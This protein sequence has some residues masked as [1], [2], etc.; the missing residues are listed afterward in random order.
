MSDAEAPTPTSKKPPSMRGRRA[1]LARACVSALAGL[2]IGEIGLRA[3]L[4]IRFHRAQAA[5][6][7]AEKTLPPGELG[8]TTLFRAVGDEDLVYGMI[9]GAKGIFFG[10]DVTINSAGYRAPEFPAAKP[11]NTLRIVMVG[12]SHGFGWR[13]SAEESIPG[14]LEGSLQALAGPSSKV[15]AY[16]L[17]VPGYNLAQKAYCLEKDGLPL[18]P[19]AVIAQVHLDDAL[20]PWLFA[21]RGFWRLDRIYLLRIAQIV[22]DLML[23]GESVL[24]GLDGSRYRDAER[25]GPLAMDAR[26]IPRRYRRLAGFGAMRRGLERMRDDCRKAGAALWVLLPA[27]HILKERAD[28]ERDPEFDSIRAMCRELGIEVI[29]PFPA[30]RAFAARYGLSDHD[31]IFPWIPDTHPSPARH[32]LT[33]AAALAPIAER[34]RIA[35]PGDPA[36]ATELAALRDRAREKLADVTLYPAEDW[37]GVPVRWMGKKAKLFVQ[38]NDGKL[39][40]PIWIANPDIESSPIR[41]RFTLEGREPVEIE[42][43]ERGYFRQTFEGCART[44]ESLM[45]EIEASRTFRESAEGRELGIALFPPG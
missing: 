11:A 22:G 40:I 5:A 24:R 30:T 34:L 15:E 1:A 7:G 38:P 2:L 42:R 35:R 4:A 21:E 14:R 23:G 13:A 19:D 27:D 9:P 8:F 20:P 32:A 25:G 12:D 17:C 26:D 31:F 43:A 33:A 44:S 3:C 41:V 10:A 16:N 39:S 29:D 37:Q 18:R 6:L 36:L 28:A 45:L